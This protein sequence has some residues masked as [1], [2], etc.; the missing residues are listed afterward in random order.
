M[1]E[2]RLQDLV[3]LVTQIPL[4]ETSSSNSGNTVIQSVTIDSFGHV[5]GLA[6]K[7][8][9]LSG[10]GYSGA[11]NAD[12]YGSWTI[13]EGNGSETSTIS[14][15]Q[16]LHIEQSTGIQV[17]LTDTRQLTIT[18]TAPDQTVS[19]TGSGATSVSGTYP[20]FTISSTD[21]NTV[22]NDGQ[23]TVSGGTDLSG[24]GS[25]TADQSG[26]SSVT[27]NHATITRTNT[28]NA[29]SLDMETTLQ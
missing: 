11:T 16:T 12:N 26:N 25:M 14:S 22:P 21:T 27:I 20:N 6:T 10:L 7:E 29:S 2:V 13:M 5:T 24:T 15:G 4:S 1:E 9:T 8:I 3:Q 23:F 19:L 28:S 17:E 18:N